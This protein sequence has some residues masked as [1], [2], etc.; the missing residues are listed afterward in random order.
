MQRIGDVLVYSPSDLNHF[1]ECEHLTYLQRTRDVAL[2][3]PVRD[4][5]A[6]LLAR[7]GLDHERAWLARFR[8]EGRSIVEIPGAEGRDW[9]A[10][11][12]RTVAAMQEGADVIYQGVLAAGD[13]HG[14]SDFLVR[15]ERP[16]RAWAWSY[17]PWDTKLARHTKPHFVLQLC[18]YAEQIAAVQG[19]EPAYMHVLLG[20]GERESLCYRDFAAYFRAVRQQFVNAVTSGRDSY[21]YPVAHC[22]LCGFLGQ[23]AARWD[24][25]DHLSLV[26]GIRRDQV[27][28]LNA[29]G[30][31]RVAHLGQLDPNVR[32]DIGTATLQRLRDQ[33]RVQSHARS[34]GEHRFHLLPPGPDNG[35]R[36]LPQPSCGDIFFDME[37]YPYFEPRGGLEYLFGAT[38]VDTGTN[39]FRAWHASNRA[40]EK[41]A[42]EG[43]IDFVHERLQ[44]WPTLHI[45]HYASYEV[46]ALKRLMSEHATREAELDELLRRQV[47]VDLYQVVRQSIRI[48][49]DS[50]SIKKVRT[51]FMPDAGRGDIADGG[52]SILEFE[53]WLAS[54]D[55]AILQA[56]TEY[57]EEDCL[58]TVK[59]RDWLL[60]QRDALRR[61]LDVEVPWRQAEPYQ[62][63]PARVEED[64][65]TETRIRRLREQGGATANL[66]A[67]LLGYHRRDA[68]PE[69]WAYFDRR[70]RA[71][72]DLLDDLESLAYLEEDPGCP[73]EAAGK[74]LVH[75]LTFPEQETKLRPESK[76][77]DPYTGGPAGEIVSVDMTTRR[78]RLKRGPSLAD[79]PVPAALI[80]DKPRD[81][82]VQRQALGRV[83]DDMLAPS[84]GGQ[85]RFGAA[86]A[87]LDRE[88]PR[89]HGS[90]PGSPIQARDLGEQQQRVAGLD[91]SCLFIQGP[92]GSGK[93]WTSARLIV[94]LIE[95]GKRVGV[96]AQ[97]HKAIHN[98]LAE[99]EM[100]AVERGISFRGLKKS[101]GAEETMFEGQFFEN[102]G[103][104]NDCDVSDASVIAGTAWQFARAGMELS[105]DYL[106]I[107]EAGQVSLADAVAMSTA[108][109][110]LVLVGDPQQLPQVTQG[111]HPENSGCSV[112]EHLLGSDATVAPERGLFLPRS[113]RMHPDVCA[114]VSELSYDGRLTSAPGCDRQRIDSRGLRGTGLRYIAVPHAGNSQQSAEEAHAIAFEIRRLLDGG[115]V[116]DAD[117]VIRRLGSADILV[118]APYNMQVRCLQAH[119]PS[120]VETETVDKFQGREAAVVFFSMASSS[121]ADIP[122]G[123]EFLF[124]RNRFNVAISR[125]RAMAVVVASPRL[126]DVR[127][128]S[129]EQMRLVNGFCRFVEHAT[130]VIAGVER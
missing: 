45:Y 55:P 39:A 98:L 27:D 130:E 18:F 19:E 1:L 51:F 25:D 10:G 72:D 12:A 68:K 23:C 3:A 4:P 124:N 109:T 57:N 17:E 69:W 6:E 79:Q 43:F 58:S 121:G 115:S 31:T 120:G 36:L 9:P 77:R 60:E 28:A 93:T 103:D 117:G 91:S 114:F 125:A 2:P 122:R 101:S 40:E 75:T 35:F 113:F 86:R 24:R 100:A 66:M 116:T 88:F 8:S 38:C 82:S 30:I 63:S 71:L 123:L 41:M 62:V 26:A 97:S 42:F 110:N 73:P 80:P 96:A 29:A 16:S 22:G 84:S 33:A 105:L 20:T 94:F 5:H 48:S 126:R 64:A 95:R 108:A 21:P 74:S 106:F 111:V 7:K 92:P 53:R 44:R 47:F 15:V 87:L 83:A 102:T 112:L 14:I 34:T 127:C 76:V 119:L 11:S 56:I 54:R 70:G 129:L 89:I 49:H 90:N 61:S 59:L 107:D 46:T 67:H 99:V 50:Y 118:V 81:N 52:E 78:V 85:V 128:Q 32:V 65:A 104:P 37:G 13:W